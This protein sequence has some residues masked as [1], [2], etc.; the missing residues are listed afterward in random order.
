MGGTS[1]ALYSLMFTAAAAKLSKINNVKDWLE[2]WAQAWRAG[3]DGIMKYSKAKLGDKTMVSN[4][5]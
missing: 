4:L 3:I 2:V 5:N 1:G